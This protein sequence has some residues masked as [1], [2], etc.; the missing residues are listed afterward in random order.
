MRSDPGR[1]VSGPARLAVRVG[2]RVIGR[3]VAEGARPAHRAVVG[4]DVPPAAGGGYLTPGGFQRLRG[5]TIVARAA[6]R[7]LDPEVA[8]PL[9]QRSAE[10]VGVDLSALAR[11]QRLAG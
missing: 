7:A 11:D 3:S 9:W 4:D 6:D 5:G 1:E 2:D 10:L 8:A